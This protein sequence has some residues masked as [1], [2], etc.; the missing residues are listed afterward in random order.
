MTT[1]MNP[2]L[3]LEGLRHTGALPFRAGPRPV[4]P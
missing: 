3:N 1:D 2:E 4:L